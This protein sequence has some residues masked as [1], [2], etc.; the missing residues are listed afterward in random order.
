M[1]VPAATGKD[2]LSLDCLAQ[3]ELFW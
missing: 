1:I 3:T 2:V